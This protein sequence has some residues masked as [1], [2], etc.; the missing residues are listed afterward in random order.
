MATEPAP[1]DGHPDLLAGAAAGV[2]R[3][4]RVPFVSY[5]YE[6]P[7]SMLKDAALLQLELNRR[8]LR[9]DLALKDASPY[10]VQW[11]GTRPVFIDVGSFERLRADEPWAGYRQFC[12]LFLYPLMLQAYKD[13]PYHAALRGSLD[14]IPPHDARAVL[15][16]ERFRKGVMSNVLLHARLEARYAG[17][18]GR[19]VKREMKRAGFNKE[20]L[21]ANFGKLDK[22]VR[23][24][25]WNAGETA[26]TGYGED[27][28][29]DEASAA[30]KADF[31]RAAAARARVEAHVGRRRQRRPLLP[32]RRRGV[33]PRGRLRRRP[34]HGRRALPAPARRG[35]RGHPPARHERHRP[36]ARPRLARAGA[37]LARAPRLTR[38]RAV[39]G[40][41]APCLHHRQRAGAG[42]PRLAARARCA[43]GDRVPRPLRPDGRAAAEREA[44][45]EQSRPTSARRS[46]ARWRS[47]SRW[48]SG[49]RSRRR[50]RCTKRTRDRLLARRAASRRALGA[51]LRAA[52]V[53]PARPQRAVLHRPRQHDGRHPGARVRLH[54]APAAGRGVRRVGARADPAG[55]RMGGDAR[56]RR[57]AG[58]GVRPAAGGGR[59]RRLGGR[60]PGRAARWGPAPRRCT[61]ASPA[62]G[63]SRPC[64]PPR[65]WSCSCSSSSSRR[66]AGC[67]RRPRRRPRCPGRRPPRRRSSRWCSTSCRR[68]RWSG[69][70]G[71]STPSCSRTSPGSR[72]SRPG[73]AT[74]R[75][76][77]TSRARRF[78]PSSRA[79]SRGSAPCRSRATTPATC[80]RCSRTR[81]S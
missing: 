73:T 63:R 59:A 11:R 75:R 67:S 72:A 16:G 57:A 76:S 6:W 28:T 13:L 18:E 79:S 24:L 49:P 50:E 39:P 25:E 78:P 45:G 20:L 9:A 40:R 48:R 54:A 2:L 60:D 70:T 38:P 22:L 10:N 21:A 58:G 32:H 56:V 55:G 69:R 26:W 62:C 80:S 71:R 65:R 35:A 77:T 23:K 7:F 46:S 53:R 29:Y 34:R 3:H 15:A 27:N 30:A 17:A 44:R 74:R 52:A 43:A 19:E 61:R 14:G 51:G 36:V 33:R 5:P 8:A 1:L 81:T 31:V 4:E 41:R 66:C 47:G 68:A 12:M 64:S 42:V 37:G